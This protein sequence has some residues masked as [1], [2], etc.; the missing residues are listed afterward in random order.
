[1]CIG[2]LMLDI[3]VRT[4][5]EIEVGTDVP[6]S[7]RLRLGGSA[8]NTCRAF[9]GLGGKAALVCAT[10]DDSLGSRL[11]TAH[12]SADVS[13]HAV[14][15]PGMTARLAAVIAPNG[16]RSFVTDRGVA[17]S[18][19]AAALKSRWFARADVLH[20]PA[21]SLL[22]AP[23]SGACVAAAE[24][25]RARAGLVSVDL[26]SRAPLLAAG[27]A[28]LDAIRHV[29]PT[30]LFANNDEAA[31]VDSLGSRLLDLA[32]IAVI[33]LGAGGC[34][35]VW[36]LPNHD[37]ETREIEIGTKPLATD[38]STGAGDAFAAG[39][40]Y[41]FISASRKQSFAT[42]LRH[43]ALSGH[44]TA[45]AMLTSARPELQL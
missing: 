20:L 34:R 23:L 5:V 4:T 29:R 33:K 40:L 18:L 14:R 26:A 25:V 21:Y 12:R 7:V 16:E 45:A 24:M 11:I 8:G 35:V 36:R 32:P 15:I 44:R 17:D 10:G 2:D 27:G 39:F 43:A 30:I 22:N 6:G 3:V 38:D 31:V 37:D 41:A 42:T 13:V 1:M 28:G 9:A 19:S